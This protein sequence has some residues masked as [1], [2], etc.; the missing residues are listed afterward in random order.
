M[1][2]RGALSILSNCRVAIVLWDVKTRNREKY[3]KRTR[4]CTVPSCTVPGDKD[5][6]TPRTSSPPQWFAMFPFAPVRL[7][8]WGVSGP[9]W[10]RAMWSR[11]AAGSRRDH[12]TRLACCVRRIMTDEPRRSKERLT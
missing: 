9:E 6:P 1:K 4:K 11:S 12:N 7:R 10:H 2:G 8:R 3:L 5:P